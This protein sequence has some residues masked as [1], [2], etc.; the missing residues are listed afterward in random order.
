MFP[1]HSFVVRLIIMFV[2]SLLIAFGMM[3]M[4]SSGYD[5]YVGCYAHQSTWSAWSSTWHAY[6]ALDMP[7][8]PYFIPRA[9]G[10]CGRQPNVAYGAAWGSAPLGTE[11]SRECGCDYPPEAAS[12]LAPI[13]FERLGQVPNDMDLGGLSPPGQRGP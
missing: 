1:R 12:S 3:L 9:P 10:D 5:G 11:E 7:L 6:N 13:R 4:P 2:F 8:R